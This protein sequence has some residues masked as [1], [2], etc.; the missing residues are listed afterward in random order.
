M[1][2]TAEE[3]SSQA[4]QLQASIAFF[5]VSGSSTERGTA[6]RRPVSVAKAPLSRSDDKTRKSEPTAPNRPNRSSGS[7]IDLCTGRP[8]EVDIHD[9]DFTSY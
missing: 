5:K 1:A 3:L 7:V 8:G 9:K 4:E 6:M 2:S